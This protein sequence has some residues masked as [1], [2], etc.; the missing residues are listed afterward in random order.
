VVGH[1]HDISGNGRRRTPRGQVRQHSNDLS[2]G[3]RVHNHES[4]PDRHPLA[5][6]RHGGRVTVQRVHDRLLLR[7]FQMEARGG[8]ATGNQFETRE[9]AALIHSV[10]RLISGGTVIMEFRQEDLSTARRQALI[11][12]TSLVILFP[13]LLIFTAI[14][15]S[16]RIFQGLEALAKGTSR[17][18]GGN[19][20]Y[21]VP[22]ESQDELGELATSFNRMADDLNQSHEAL[23][24]ECDAH[25]QKAEALR[26]A[27]EQLKE[28]MQKLQRAQVQIVQQERILAL[29][30]ISS[31]MMRDFNEALT[32]IIGI[33]EMLRSHEELE[34]TRED[35]KEYFSVIHDSATRATKVIKQLSAFFTPHE[36]TPRMPVYLS[37]VVEN[38]LSLTRPLWKEQQEAENLKVEIIRNLENVDPIEVD[39]DGLVEMTSKLII[40]A[41]EAMPSGGQMQFA[42]RM[43]NDE[44]VLEIRDTGRGMDE[45]TTQ[46][47]FEPFFTTKREASGMGLAVVSGTV[48]RHEGTVT[49]DSKE[50]EGT[51]WTL[52]FPARALFNIE[53]TPPPIAPADLPN[54]RIL[55]VD[56]DANVS[57]VLARILRVEGHTVETADCGEDGFR[58]FRAGTFD[59][60]LTDLAMPFWW[61][62]KLSASKN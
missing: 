51:V 32:P 7:E 42:T 34:P 18:A 16:R 2:G 48:L 53:V 39:F 44:V 57:R 55:V 62:A 56:D 37:D 33:T 17:I 40:N 25:R 41:V 3:R 30:Q 52:R 13:G 9:G 12:I 54:L 61:R 60:L 8:V 11:W 22:V 26:V 49:L 47:C 24:S 58:K 27:N 6:P 20:D 45:S 21:R 28:A 31:G 15:T 36:N 5:V 14:V 29:K 4:L 50:G 1:D 46:R 38:A 23:S 10:D 59:L 35:L 43:D 19:R